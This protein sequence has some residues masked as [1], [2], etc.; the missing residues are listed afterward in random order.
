MSFVFG[1]CS[2]NW[3]FVFYGVWVVSYDIEGVFEIGVWGF[4]N[5]EVKF[6]EVCR[7]GVEGGRKGYDFV[8]GGNGSRKSC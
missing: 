8:R 2:W 1:Y 7:G 3:W 6:G 5:G 4:W